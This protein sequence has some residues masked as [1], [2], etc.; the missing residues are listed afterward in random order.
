[1]LIWVKHMRKRIVRFLDT[2][3]QNAIVSVMAIVMIALAT[4]SAGALLY[5]YQV[6]V[7][8]SFPYSNP[9]ALGFV[10]RVDANGAVGKTLSE[11]DW[12]GLAQHAG[13]VA[14]FALYRPNY[15]AILSPGSATY[16]A[17]ADVTN[18]FFRVLGVSPI[19]GSGFVDR[20]AA[21]SN[22]VLISDRFWRSQL[23]S[24]EHVVGSELRIGANSYTV[25]GVMPRSVEFPSLE[26]DVWRLYSPSPT[27]TGLDAYVLARLRAGMNVRSGNHALVSLAD[28]WKSESSLW[29]DWIPKIVSLRETSAEPF[30]QA[31]SLLFAA[32]LLIFLLAFVNLAS[33]SFAT[34]RAKQDEVWLRSVLGM[35]PWRL[36]WYSF[37]ETLPPTL[38]GTALGILLTSPLAREFVSFVSTSTTSPVQL[39][40]HPLLSSI[41]IVPVVASTVSGIAGLI[42]ART[43]ESWILVATEHGIGRTRQRGHSGRKKVYATALVV[44]SALAVS[45]TATAL[46]LIQSYVNVSNVELGLDPSNVL[47]AGI[48]V[49][50]NE[51]PPDVARTRATFREILRSLESTPGIH[52]AAIVES[53]LYRG[54]NLATIAAFDGPKAN[55]SP[56]PQAEVRVVSEGYF[57]ALDIKLISGRTLSEH[58]GTSEAR[59]VVV[60]EMLAQTLWPN[61][62]ALGKRIAFG[63]L[64][65][66]VWYEVVGLVRPVRDI[67][68][69]AQPTPTLYVSFWQL[70]GDF[71]ALIAKC[72]GDPLL[73]LPT[74][75]AAI[76]VVHPFAPLAQPMRLSD[77][78]LERSASSLVAARFFGLFAVIAFLIAFAGIYTIAS[79]RALAERFDNAVRLVFGASSYII[80]K[81]SILNTGLV[82]FLGGIFGSVLMF[83]L[84]RVSSSYLFGVADQYAI[85]LAAALAILLISAV[86]GSVP[87]AVQATSTNIANV[88]RGRD[89]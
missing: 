29:G 70:G 14:D 47:I 21:G 75:R 71:A 53:G 55:I 66:P 26:T 85:A 22:Q 35:T 49:D 30:Q 67:D 6:T 60:D 46:L 78:A 12:F 62:T 54:V 73:T 65:T 9:E 17:V 87:Y 42:G 2:S 1:L 20:T 81:A 19:K 43:A 15:Q 83:A 64:A 79:E 10:F 76:A 16:V 4:G 89:S 74:V 86:A 24:S 57:Q 80:I 7:N 58:D 5:T 25:S 68:V 23:Q 50:A 3:R 61:Q 34:M 56:P 41:F 88:L 8:R 37:G 36:V 13:S 51:T 39:Q 44:Q 31:I 59:V 27:E 33:F 48:T 32:T 40:D 69:I 28:R 63:N 18:N 11:A 38:A 84:I 52:R 45:L 72:S 77:L 82:L